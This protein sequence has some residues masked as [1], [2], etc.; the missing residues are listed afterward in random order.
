MDPRDS[1][2]TRFLYAKLLRYIMQ[3]KSVGKKSCGISYQRTA[4]ILSLST[5]YAKP[6]DPELPQSID[7]TVT[8]KS[9]HQIICQWIPEE[10]TKTYII[11]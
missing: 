2:Q 8:T 6:P 3:N 7:S 11:S 4:T 10:T 5:S 9:N 1:K